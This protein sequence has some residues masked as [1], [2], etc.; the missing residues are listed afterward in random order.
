MLRL[1]K[2]VGVLSKE[3]M[4]IEMYDG[5]RQKELEDRIA[6][7]FSSLLSICELYKIDLLVAYSRKISKIS[8]IISKWHEKYGTHLKQLREKFD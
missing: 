3:I 4:E 2:G 5:L 1:F 6:D 7:F 8:K